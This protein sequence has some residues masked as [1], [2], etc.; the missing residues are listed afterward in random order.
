M[1]KPIYTKEFIENLIKDIIYK[2]SY[3]DVHYAAKQY[4]SKLGMN[5]TPGDK[6]FLELK[7]IEMDRYGYTD[8]DMDDDSIEDEINRSTKYEFR[9]KYNMDYEG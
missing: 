5:F 7:Q 8:E 1:P 6:E 4:A 9:K 3:G 2:D